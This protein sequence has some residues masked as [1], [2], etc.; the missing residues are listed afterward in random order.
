MND[1]TICNLALGHLGDIAN[2][3]SINPPDQ[4]V[5]AQL[6]KRFYP[7]ARNA[8]LEMSS[9]GFATVRAKL[10]Q[11]GNPTLAI[12]Q[13]V[14]PAATQGTWQFAYALPNDVINVIS[15]LPAAAIDDYEARF[16][17][18]DQPSFPSF[19]QGSIPVPGAMAYMPQPFVM[20]TQADGT[21]IVLTNTVDA[22]LRFTRA[23]T[24]TTKYSP[25]FSLALSHFLASMLAGPLLKGDAGM[26][27][28]QAQLALFKAVEG[29]AEASDANQRKL[30]IEPSPSWIR[31]R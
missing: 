3:K 16:W 29:W 17:P 26:K 27:A 12:A 18:T 28:S 4:S 31:G 5:Q 21:Q 19:P 15:V 8:L 24:D 13:G 20:E 1:V 9:W 10:A 11:I 23:V 14:D 2:V 7:A 6:C 22:V 30:N 25:L